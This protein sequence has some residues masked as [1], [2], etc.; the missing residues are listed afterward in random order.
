M[1][2]VGMFIGVEMGVNVERW[3]TAGKKRSYLH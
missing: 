3:W 2:C 1:K